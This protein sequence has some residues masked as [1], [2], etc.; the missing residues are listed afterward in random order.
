MPL[1]WLYSSGTQADAILSLGRGFIGIS[2]AVV[3]IIGIALL[4]AIFRVRAPQ[5]L[6]PEG[7]Q[8]LDSR[9]NGA[10]FV[11]V[12]VG[13]STLVLIASAAWAMSTLNRVAR[14]PAD[15]PLT[16]EIAAHQ[17]WWEVRYLN[18][19]ASRIFITANEMHIPVGEPVR[20]RF[21]S[22][23][24]IH[25]FW[26]PALAGKMDIIPGRTNATWLDAKQPGTYFGECS[27]FCGLQHAHMVFRVIAD[28]PSAFQAWW[29]AQLKTAPTT[30][31]SDEHGRELF[32]RS[33]GACHTVRG[34]EAGGIYGPDL[35][36][37][38]SRGMIAASLP[39]TPDRLAAWIADPQALK[40]GTLMPKVELSDAD[41][42]VVTSF[43]ETLR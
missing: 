41:L 43:V 20:L 36:H 18:A 1:N 39:N 30:P 8:P 16:I 19:V 21:V 27:E 32:L 28:P 15:G 14:E 42:R 35:T 23:D 11:Y 33:C 3:A 7:R 31:G 26:V 38:M 12:G 37:L 29:N 10:A 22:A 24:V 40:P 9:G 13:I 6:D 4:I 34:T 2:L 25:S 5:P 17:W